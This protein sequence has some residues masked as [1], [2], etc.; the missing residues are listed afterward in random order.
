[1]GTCREALCRAGFVKIAPRTILIM[2]LSSSY[3]SPVAVMSSNERSRAL[4]ASRIRRRRWTE[5]EVVGRHRTPGRDIAAPPYL[6][7]RPRPRRSASVSAS[8]WPLGVAP[9]KGRR[10]VNVGLLIGGYG[11]GQGAI[12]AVQTWLFARGDFDLLSAFGTHFSFLMLG[13]FVIDVGSTTTLARQVAGASGERAGADIWP[14]FWNTVAVR[15]GAAIVVAVAALVVAMLPSSDPFSRAY[16]IASLPGLLIWA[17]NAVGLLD[18]LK[19]SGLSGVTGAITFAA[20]AISLAFAPSVPPGTAG[21]MLGCAFS[22]GYALTVVSQWGVLV[23]LGRRPVWSRPSRDGILRAARDGLALL[24]QLV[25]GQLI[26][27]VQLLLSTSFLGAESTALLIYAKQIVI[28][29]TMLVGFV[30]RVD[31][32]ALVE[33][34]T[35]AENHGFATILRAQTTSIATAF[36]LALGTFAMS[37]LALMV[38][39]YGFTQAAF[40]IAAYAPSIMTISALLIMIQGLAAIGDYASSAR[41]IA[42]STLIGA[43]VSY[44]MIGPCGIYAFVIGEVAFHL[45]GAGLIYLRLRRRSR[46]AAA[47]PAY[48]LISSSRRERRCRSKPRT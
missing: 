42:I 12:F 5:G 13:I 4:R 7:K 11:I 30:I 20:S 31:F 8:A 15:L 23:R 40:L 22:I 25:P 9:A 37:L 28:A 26:L 39:Q 41:I 43:I 48:H 35:R 17:V 38:P 46:P 19:L 36:I 16:L 44:L 18:G 24:S 2:E 27:R 33:T 6:S 47:K 45:L 29:M 3:H 14:S 1:M 21:A 10:I 34:M 32:P